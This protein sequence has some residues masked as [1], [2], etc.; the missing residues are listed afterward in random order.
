MTPEEIEEEGLTD[1]VHKR[2]FKNGARPGLTC[3]AITG[4]PTVRQQDRAWMQPE[5]IPE[6]A[7]KMKM[8]GCV[9]NNHFYSFD[10]II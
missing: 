8:I 2:R 5:R 10:N 9:M 4:G 7:V 6:R 3:K 1:F